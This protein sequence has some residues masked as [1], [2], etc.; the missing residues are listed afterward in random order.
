MDGTHSAMLFIH[1]QDAHWRT[2]RYELML[3]PVYLLL[4]RPLPK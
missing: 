4:W 1:S 3:F 2:A